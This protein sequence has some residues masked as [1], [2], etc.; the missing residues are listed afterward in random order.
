MSEALALA[1]NP[2][3]SPEKLIALLSENQGNDEVLSAIAVHPNM[4]KELL[5]EIVHYDNPGEKE[6]IYRYDHFGKQMKH[7]KETERNPVIDLL[8]LQHPNLVEEIYLECFDDQSYLYH[9]EYDDLEAF[10]TED[11]VYLSFLADLPDWF[12]EIGVKHKNKN[13]RAFVAARIG[14]ASEKYLERLL[15]DECD[16][17][18]YAMACSPGVSE[19]VLEKLFEN[20]EPGVNEGLAQNENT[21]FSILEQL[22]QDENFNVK[23]AVA[24]SIHTPA[25]IFEQL[26]RDEDLDVR[27]AV[28]KN[29]YT[30]AKIFEQL[31][32]DENLDVRNAVARN[33]N[34]PASIRESLAREK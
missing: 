15:K 24:E 33:G 22:A 5:V 20:K 27:I 7:F 32:R 13:L 29:M 11:G 10:S 23:I 16:W 14:G 17:V 26:A 3:T 31:A 21:P 28:A 9:R 12:T 1:T 8:L 30:P 4:T 6:G 34:V 19:R 25:E 18:R 2:N